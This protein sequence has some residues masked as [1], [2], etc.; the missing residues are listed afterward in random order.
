[1]LVTLT[2]SAVRDSLTVR[3]PDCTCVVVIY[4]K[5]VRC[6]SHQESEY[7][8]VAGMDPGAGPCAGLGS[9][10]AFAR[11]ARSPGPGNIQTQRGNVAC[12]Q[13]HLEL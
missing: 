1:M 7:T 6:Q 11:M 8:V 4:Q 3:G 9:T 5:S 2:S 10:A 13:G 12:V